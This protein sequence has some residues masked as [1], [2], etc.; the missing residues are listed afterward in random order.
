MKTKTFGAFKLAIIEQSPIN[1]DWKRL[2]ELSFKN[3]V[4]GTI[5]IPV[6]EWENEERLNTL[7]QSVILLTSY[8]FTD[9]LLDAS[10]L[11]LADE[12]TQLY[13]AFF[14]FDINYYVKITDKRRL[15]KIF[16]DNVIVEGRLV[17]I[18]NMDN[19]K[20]A[21]L[22]FYQYSKT[23]GL[24]LIGWMITAVETFSNDD[25]LKIEVEK[26]KHAKENN[27]GYEFTVGSYRYCYFFDDNGY[28][29]SVN[30]GPS[31]RVQFEET[32]GKDA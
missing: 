6:E 22:S 31:E 24:K 27:Q 28:T 20:F 11:K 12:P 16:P 8:G 15:L 32:G 9:Y 13:L 5:L 19:E 4:I 17:E 30:G 18:T 2:L 26:V 14:R 7:I 3:E 29:F 10:M 1:L 25:L 21:N 23:N